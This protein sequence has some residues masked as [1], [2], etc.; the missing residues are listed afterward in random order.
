MQNNNNC[1]RFGVGLKSNK[2]TNDF[3]RCLWSRMAAIFGKVAW[4]YSPFRINTT[5]I[6]G[7]VDIGKDG[8]IEVRLHYNQRGCLAYIEFIPINVVN[9]LKNML[10]QC[11]N[12]ALQFEKYVNKVHIYGYFDQNLLFFKRVGKYFEI[13]GNKICLTVNGYDKEDCFALCKIQFQQ[14][15]NL[16]TF[17]TLR[18]ITAKGSLTEEIREKRNFIT[19]L[20]NEQTGEEICMM[21]K[22][23][24]YQNLVVSDSMTSYID[25]YLERPYYYEDHFTNFDKSVQ[26]FAQGVRNEEFSEMT[27]GSFEPYVEEAI[28]NYMSALEVITLDDKEPKHCDCCGQMKYSIARRVTD[29]ANKAING[30]GEFVKD[31]YG[32]RSKY[33]HTGSLLSSNNYTGRTIPLMSKSS[34]NGLIE[35]VSRIDHEMKKWVKECIE[36]HESN[37]NH[38]PIYISTSKI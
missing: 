30:L 20:V 25:T 37:A 1:F 18:Y 15:C 12:E 13:E 29:L 22:N 31:Y 28:V 11:V 35:Q 6:V 27:L 21:E 32:N 8:F 7:Q 33:V 19:K 4:L 36:W 14:V 5:I 34:K 2:E 17:D 9:N 38:K 10:K 16:L 3:L 23:K 26:L 24:M